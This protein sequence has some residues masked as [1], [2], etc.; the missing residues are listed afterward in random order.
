MRIQRSKPQ[1]RA[2]SL[3]SQKHKNRRGIVVVLTGFALVAIFAFVALSV[4][5]GRIVVTEN[6]MQNAVDA[7]ALAASQEITVAAQVAVSAG[8]SGASATQA[9]VAA[10]RLMAAEVAAANN[11]YINPDTDV[12][13]GKRQYNAAADEWTTVWGTSPFNAVRVTARRTEPKPMRLHPM[14][15]FHSPLVGRSAVRKCPFK[16]PP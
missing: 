10:A 8:G 14:V 7:A 11:V 6:Q 4:D 3:K 16:P 1:P 5:S 12:Q 13:F 15:S 9:A 2:H